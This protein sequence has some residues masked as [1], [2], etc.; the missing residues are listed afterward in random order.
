MST[1][2]LPYSTLSPQPPHT[3][4]LFRLAGRLLVLQ[5]Q[6][7]MSPF[8]HDL[9]MACKTPAA[10]TACTKADSLLGTSSMIGPY[11]LELEMV[12]Q[13]H[14]LNLNCH[15]HSMMPMRAPLAMAV[16]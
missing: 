9:A 6:V 10:E 1:K 5:P 13:F 16:T 12:E 2:C 11:T 4:S 15:W 8:R 3:Q 7:L 14:W